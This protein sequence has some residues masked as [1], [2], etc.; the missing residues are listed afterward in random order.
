MTKVGV[1]GLG[2]MGQTHLDAYA[3]LD[4]AQVVAIADADPDRLSGKAKAGG[5][6]E[7]AAA[8]DDQLTGVARY[9]DASALIADDDVQLVDICLPTPLHLRFAEQ[10]IA[11]GKHVLIEKPLARTSEDALSIAE[12]AEQSDVIAMPAMC[13]RFWPGWTW[14]KQTIDQ[15][16]YGK[17]LA[18]HFQRIGA[19]I[20]GSFYEDGTRSGGAILDI[21]LHDTDFVN[22]LF[23]VPNTVTSAGYSHLSG[24]IDYVRTRLQYDHDTLVTAEG[25]WM[26]HPQFRFT[27]RYLAN[28]ER[29]TAVYD[30]GAE[31]AL[32]LY[33]PGKDPQAVAL[34]PHMGY[35]YEV[36]YMVECIEQ[37]VAPQ[38]VTLR[39]AADSIRIVEAESQSAKTGRS[40]AL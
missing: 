20:A 4:N 22:H 23:G 18:V 34:D 10:A 31:N 37:G 6:I 29:A 12:L 25:G 36:A 9:S 40:V 16:T 13:M 38:T 5:N 17:T 15:Q 33:E 24:E 2:M 39:Q 30:I 1:I 35:D 28:F 11:A 3:R 7:G 19:I 14:L 21:H 26:A 8:G 32:T 27:M